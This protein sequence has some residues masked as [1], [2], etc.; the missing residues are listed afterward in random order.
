ML[1]P[2]QAIVDL[3]ALQHNLKTASKLSG[4]KTIAVIKSNAYGHGILRAASCLAFLEQTHSFAVAF[5]DEGAIL[6]QHLYKIGSS[7]EITALQGFYSPDNL[8]LYLEHDLIATIH[9]K[10]QINILAK[11]KLHKFSRPLKVW[12]KHNSGM[13]RLGLSANELI[14]AYRKT[15]ANP[16]VHIFGIMTHLATA[17]REDISDS[18]EQLQRLYKAI[19]PIQK[20]R[21]AL[22]QQPL[23]ISI[24][25]SAALCN[26]ALS[27][28]IALK[29]NYSR[30]GIMLY[31]ASPLD[32]TTAKEIGLR[33][34]MKLK[35][36]LI[37]V[38]QLKSGDSVGYE[39]LWRA[40]HDCVMGVVPIGYGDGYPY[41]SQPCK[42][43]VLVK[44]EKCFL[45][46][47]TSM[48]MLCI[49]LSGCT[50]PKPGDEVELWGDNLPTNEVAAAF[51]TVV[52][53]LT[54]S[55]TPR[56]PLKYV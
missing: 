42:V 9:H 40:S 13:N 18:E 53:R 22:N 49:D 34:V 32:G 24:S 29:E 43:P 12:F 31:G 19:E 14:N 26:P 15:I 20:Q 44:G 10:E 38:R 27:K 52:N 55:L 23:S 41:R 5:A 51:D 46:G 28:M 25:N 56:I 21:A 8:Q 2:T 33:P 54:S 30:P 39:G 36:K 11:H 35:S 3:S 48:D 6:R 47:R 4:G 17:N 45:S 1:R 50:D 37:S 16:Y 7:K